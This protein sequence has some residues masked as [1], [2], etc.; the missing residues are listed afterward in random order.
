MKKSIVLLSASILVLVST[1]LVLFPPLEG[2]SFH[3]ESGESRPS[4]KAVEI[5]LTNFHDSRVDIFFV[6]NDSL[7]YDLS[8]DTFEALPNETAFNVVHRELLDKY[9]L[10]LNRF[11]ENG[12][13]WVAGSSRLK[14]VTLVLSS[15]REY[16]ISIY[17]DGV[18]NT[19]IAY[20]NGANID[21]KSEFVYLAKGGLN[22]TLDEDVV[23]SDGMFQVIVST[24]Q[25]DL[26]LDLP[27]HVTGQVVFSSLGLVQLVEWDGWLV[28]DE[29]SNV[30]ETSLDRLNPSIYV[31]A[32]SELTRASLVS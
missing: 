3:F 14:S 12:S 16:S 26:S 23:I 1:A 6:E 5:R 17:S 25:L 11:Y 10:S 15:S 18:L 32:T 21:G 28:D 19:T 2:A 24:N 31:S 8:I 4:G 29:H 9:L 20:T 30:L 13:L 27:D 7:L 22:F